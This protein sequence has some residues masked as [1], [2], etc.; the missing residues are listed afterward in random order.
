MEFFFLFRMGVLL[1]GKRLI[2]VGQLGGRVQ[3]KKAGLM[4]VV[5]DRPCIS[6]FLA[7]ELIVSFGDCFGG[8][9]N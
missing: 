4:P 6:K 3:R 5:Y 2:G 9:S 7:D 8:M 1:A